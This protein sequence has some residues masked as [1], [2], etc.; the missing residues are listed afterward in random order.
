[1]A[2]VA[3]ARRAEL[4]VL[5][6]GETLDEQEAGGDHADAHG[7]DEIDEYRQAEHQQHQHHALPGS[8]RNAL[9]VAPVDD[10]HA[11]LDQNAR[12]HRVRNFGGEGPRTDDDHEQSQRMQGSGYGRCTAAADVDHGTH[13][14]AGAG[15]AAEQARHRDAYALA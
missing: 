2:A 1:V 9:E 15:Q 4:G 10:V 5:Q 14:G 7:H 6:V 13:G 11:N 3:A 12:Q 8:V